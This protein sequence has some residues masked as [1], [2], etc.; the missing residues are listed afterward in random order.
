MIDDGVQ[1]TVKF[2]SLKFHQ[3]SRSLQ[4]EFS[5]INE[6][7]SQISVKRE[8]K[9]F[10]NGWVKM[11]ILFFTGDLIFQFKTSHGETS[12]EMGLVKREEII[13]YISDNVLKL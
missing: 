5:K 9:L 10:P 13:Y 2:F 7:S 11:F 8:Q 12:S 4:P 6:R 3:D 1:H